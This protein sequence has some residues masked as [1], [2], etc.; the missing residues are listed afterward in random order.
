VASWFSGEW[1]LFNERSML[2]QI[3]GELVVRRPDR[4]MIQLEGGE[5]V[6][7]DFKFG[8]RRQEYRQQVY[9]YM[10]WLRQMG[11]PQVKGYLWYVYK[12]ELEEVTL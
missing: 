6:V 3:D 10:Q 9:E 5:V 4:V 1:E 12:N 11:H 7:V 2:Q 8:K